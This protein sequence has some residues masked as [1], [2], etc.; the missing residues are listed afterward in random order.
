M[1]FRQSVPP[2]AEVCP[3]LSGQA[4]DDA[5][6]WAVGRYRPARMGGWLRYVRFGGS[7]HGQQDGPGCANHADC[8]HAAGADADRRHDPSEHLSRGQETSAG[9]GLQG[10]GAILHRPEQEPAAA[11]A[12][13]RPNADAD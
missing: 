3:A 1:R 5:H 6:Q 7:G 12:E 10:R 11:A 9:A 4:R 2:D 13:S 8:W